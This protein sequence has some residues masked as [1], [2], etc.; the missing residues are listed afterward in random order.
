MIHLDTSFLVDLLREGRRGEEGPA[1]ELLDRLADEEMGISV[2]AACE[3]FAGAELAGNRRRERESVGALCAGLHLAVP[4]ERFA[5]R[6]GRLLADLRR[7]GQTAATMDLLI[8]TAA[9]L[10][11]AALVTRNVRHFSGVPGL[12]LIEY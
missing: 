7:T 4:D 6:Y 3:L 10:A 2:H 12:E 8:A 1:T 11:D 5:P 9:V